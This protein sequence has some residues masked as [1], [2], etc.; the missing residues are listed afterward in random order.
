[1]QPGQVNAILTD[2]LIGL[3]TVKHEGVPGDLSVDTA[4]AIG[5]AVGVVG[6]ACAL[7][8]RDIEDIRVAEE[9]RAG[10][11]AHVD[12]QVQPV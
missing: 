9:V 3:R 5:E 8:Q 7:V 4:F 2:A 10:R 6:K 12:D 11:E 1:M